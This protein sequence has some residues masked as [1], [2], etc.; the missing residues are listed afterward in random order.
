[1]SGTERVGNRIHLGVVREVGQV[2]KGT[3]GELS[4]PF[5]IV[6]VGA[7]C[8][9]G[10]G[11]GSTIAPPG[12]T[13]PAT[14]SAAATASAPLPPTPAPP[15]PPP[16]TAAPTPP[17]PDSVILSQLAAARIANATRIPL[18]SPALVALG[19]SLFFDKI[20]SGNRNISCSTCHAPAFA[21]EH[22]LPLSLGEGATGAGTARQATAASQVIARNAP[23]LFH[24]G[25]RG[26]DVLFRDGRVRRDPVTGAL[27]TPEPALNGPN[28]Q[29][30][31]LAAPLTT[32]LAAQ[33]LF[34]VATA[35]EMLGQPGE[36]ELANAP[37]E[38]T[39][40]A[41]VMA[42]LVG[43]QNG[44]KGGVAAYRALFAAAYPGLSFDALNFSHAARA[45]A[46]FESAAFTA[47]DT[48]L[49]R[50]LN[51][52]TTALS[53]A[54]KRGA[55]TFSGPGRCVACHSGPLLTDLAPHALAVP[56]LGPG[57]A[58]GDDL[59]VA[60]VSGNPADDYRFKTPPLRNVALSGPFMHDGAFA[61]LTRVLQHYRDPARSL[62][63]YQPAL[64]LP[65]FFQPLFDSNAAE[66]SAR[67][68]AIDPRIGNGIPLSDAEIADVVAFLQALTDPAATTPPA[69]P[70][71]VASGLPVG[72]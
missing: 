64:E 52:D 4:L 45:I 25:A 71:S 42:R 57:K 33:A 5:F 14:P 12:T 50:Y 37:D 72:D 70:P 24:S 15:P 63:G 22:G 18:E 49:D 43:T 40:W 54:A 3:L 16:G 60:L 51:G 6:M 8:S 20:L 56:Q 7:G 36:N 47:L 2:R 27:A 26:Y 61:S 68:A 41:L 55:V 23:P 19:Q 10:G 11:S 39:V 31:D 13:A 58:N 69:P 29:R 34:P 17:P 67:L 48:P 44:T 53:D 38:I 59:G 21:T 28:P 35:A 65:A 1:M 30:P 32:A 66:D 9:S 62:L 46:A